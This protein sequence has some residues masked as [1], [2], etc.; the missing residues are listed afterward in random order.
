MPINWHIATQ[1]PTNI[2]LSLLH[3]K[4]LKIAKSLKIKNPLFSQNIPNQNPKT[5]SNGSLKFSCHGAFGI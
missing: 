1:I 5:S 3:L 2:A 4:N